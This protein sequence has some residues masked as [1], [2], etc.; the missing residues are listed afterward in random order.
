M[1]PDPY[2]RLPQLPT[3]SL[4]SNDVTN[5][6]Q[7]QLPQV[8]EMTGMGGQDISPH[9]SW[10][11]APGDT[12]SFTVT[13]FDPDAPTPSG[14]WHWAVFNIPAEVTELATGAG[15][16]GS[17]LLPAEASTLRNDGGFAGYVGAAPPPGHGAH[18]YFYTVHAVDVPVLEIPE[19]A[20]PAMLSFQLYMTAL[21]RAS[22]YAEFEVPKS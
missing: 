22:I 19:D 17:E 4:T 3:F 18:R 16:P 13:A 7:L 2:A 11:G 1:L 10:T 12:K 14:F 5:G 8:S 20:S 15:T 9:L 6:T 21:A